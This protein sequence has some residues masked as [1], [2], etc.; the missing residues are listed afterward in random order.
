MIPHWPHQPQVPPRIPIMHSTVRQ[1]DCKRNRVLAVGCDEHPLRRLIVKQAVHISNG[2]V[3][4]TL[5]R[6][7]P[8]LRDEDPLPPPQPHP[9]GII[10]PNRR[11]LCQR[12]RQLHRLPSL[13]PIPREH[14]QPQG[15][16]QHPPFRRRPKTPII[17]PPTTHPFPAT[18]PPPRAAPPR[19]THTLPL[20]PPLPPPPPT[21]AVIADK[22]PTPRLVVHHTHV[23][24][25][26][27]RG[28][29]DIR[30]DLPRRKSAI[31]RKKRKSAI[32][33]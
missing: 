23:D 26:R 29:P 17:L 31:R 9:P 30:S 19:T 27:L 5:P 18:T 11:P 24:R 33:A 6:S 32:V 21:P 10:D 4:Q 1:V 15:R 8:V 2:K 7:A 14:R 13:P 28:I 25:R 20:P 12:L 16:R 3:L 22:Y